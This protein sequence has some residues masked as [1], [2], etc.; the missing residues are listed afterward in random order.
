MVTC[1]SEI[2]RS[3]TFCILKVGERT[4]L[5]ASK[6]SQQVSDNSHQDSYITHSQSDGNVPM[7]PHKNSERGYKYED[8]KSSGNSNDIDN[9]TSKVLTSSENSQANGAPPGQ[10]A[11]SHGDHDFED[12]GDLISK[13]LQA[14]TSVTDCSDVCSTLPQRSGSSVTMEISDLLAVDA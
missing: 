2:T 9:A 8:R 3:I 4:A 1:W 6:S 5:I 12:S 10:I 11:G 7:L 13:M 14:T